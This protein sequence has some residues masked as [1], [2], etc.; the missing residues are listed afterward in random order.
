MKRN[1]ILM[2]DIRGNLSP[3]SKEVIARHQKY[4]EKLVKFSEPENIMF[5]I[6]S[7][8]KYQSQINSAGFEL[9]FLGSRFLTNFAYI[10]KVLRTIQKSRQQIGL[11]V[12]GDPWESFWFSAFLAHVLRIK[13]PIQ[14]Q[15]HADIGSLEW[16]NLNIRNQIRSHFFWFALRYSQSVR[17]TSQQQLI[18]VQN[19]GIDL[20]QDYIVVP[21]PLNLPSQGIPIGTSSKRPNTIGLIGRIHE[22]RG[23]DSFVFFIRKL[24]EVRADFSVV[25]AGDGESRVS[26]LSELRSVL[27]D[28]RVAYLGEL[29]TY[30]L[31]H[32]WKE[33][34][35]LINAAPAESYGRTIRESIVNGVPVIAIISNGV[36]N[37]IQELGPGPISIYSSEMSSL[38]IDT[39]FRLA[40]SQKISNEIKALII[41]Q[42]ENNATKLVQDW[43]RIMAK[44]LE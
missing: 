26:F 40:L 39:L 3:T 22:D 42:N 4:G 32:A 41:T 2:L 1:K 30:E 14:V 5:Q 31:A 21:V 37:A 29:S 43:I 33:I 10:L 17:F 44:G 38:Q 19:T 6:L 35:V 27:G 11:M 12:C 9:R 20:K 23:L 16:K 24:N 36:L 18:G 34:G 7:K 13:V 15:I 28:N 8:S 25:V